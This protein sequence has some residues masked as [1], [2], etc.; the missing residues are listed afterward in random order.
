VIK[1][2]LDQVNP[3]RIAG[4][5]DRANANKDTQ[6]FTE[7]AFRIRNTRDDWT[8]ALGVVQ[9]LRVDGQA[10]ASVPLWDSGAAATVIEH[11]TKS[12]H[13]IAQ[14]GYIDVSIPIAAY[15]GV[16]D[17]ED[18]ALSYSI[19]FDNGSGGST[20]NG[21]DM[22]SLVRTSSNTAMNSTGSW[23]LN[24]AGSTIAFRVQMPYV[25]AVTGDIR[26]NVSMTG[27][28]SGLNETLS[29][30]FRV[31]PVWQQIT[32][33]NNECLYRDGSNIY[34]QHGLSGGGNCD[35]GNSNNQRFDYNLYTE[36]L[37]NLGAGTSQ[38]VW[39]NNSGSN[40]VYLTSCDA[41]AQNQKWYWSNGTT[42]YNRAYSPKLCG[43]L[44]GN[45]ILQNSC[46]WDTTGWR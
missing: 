45:L 21:M 29:Y 12:R 41:S 3:D 6:N 20:I 8:N 42:M 5:G 9:A 38:C 17:V 7:V 2:R 44:W 40:Q 46:S 27:N 35:S 18:T 22:L 13:Q 33:T 23:G 25:T 43:A 15:A 39:T 1:V 31:S 10:S 11:R 14:H 30:R 19:S 28:Q 4:L 32:V 26:V 34:W 37:R 36:Q 24:P 16:Y